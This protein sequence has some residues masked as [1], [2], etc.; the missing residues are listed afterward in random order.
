MHLQPAVKRG[1]RLTGRMWNNR[2]VDFKCALQRQFKRLGD[3]HG[4]GKD[5]INFFTERKVVISW[6]V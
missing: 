6:W 2:S 3:L 5:G 1:A 4:Q